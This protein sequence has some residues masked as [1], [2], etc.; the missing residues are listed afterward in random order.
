MYSQSVGDQTR[1]FQM[2]RSNSQLKVQM[3]RLVAE[4]ASGQIHS[5]AEAVNADFTG[6]GS[7]ESALS[8]LEAFSISLAETG[9]HVSAAQTVL[10]GIQDISGKSGPS[11]LVA[12]NTA[13]PMQIHTAST[14][15]KQTLETV[16]S[17]LNTQVAGRSLFS[18]AAT[19]RRALASSDEIIAA[20]RTLLTGA[21]TATDVID[22]V[23][24]WFENGG[25]FE[26]LIY[27]GSQTPL[28]ARPIGP[29]ETAEMP[30]S[31]TD[32]AIKNVLLGLVLGTF[33]E[34]G[35]PDLDVEGRTQI[36]QAA[37][38]AHLTAEGGLSN[39]RAEI[40][41]TEA[42]IDGA[43]ARSVAERDSLSLVRNGILA[44]DPYQA[45][46]ELE[47]ISAQLETLYAMTA[48][49]SRLS[50]ADYLR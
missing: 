3:D 9:A 15:A 2:A 42:K 19:D 5:V 14:D 33:A 27:S 30:P 23:S 13:N 10:G 4:L 16:V 37:G 39:L 29:G 26:N 22:T 35:L 38:L 49:L 47:Q 34:D 18:G 31:A 41:T 48:R 12:A 17:M 40:G 8:Q 1:I 7:I 36:M 43:T 45:A 32:P 6:L 20:V 50:L 44:S 21:T 24:D 11:F 28:G 25:G 46:S